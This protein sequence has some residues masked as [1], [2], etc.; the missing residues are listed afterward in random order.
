MEPVFRMELQ[1]LTP[2]L[3]DKL[4]IGHFCQKDLQL[5]SHN[6]FELAYVERGTATHQL[7][8]RRSVLK[9]G[10]YFVVDY[11]SAHSYADC[12]DFELI[13]CLFAPEALDETL[14]DCR[15]FDR[16]MRE[17][18]FHYQKIAVGQT[19]ANRVFSDADGQILQLLRGMLAE[20]TTRETGYAEIFRC[21]L[22]EILILTMR[23][24]VRQPGI[25][26]VGPAVEKLLEYLAQ[27]YAQPNLLSSFCRDCHYNIAYISR[28]FRQ[29][30]GTGYRQYLQRLRIEKSCRLL[31]SG[32]TKISEIAGQVGYT[33]VKTFHAVFR[34]LLG[35]T[36][37]AYRR[38]Y[39]ACF[40][41]GTVATDANRG[42]K[43]EEM[44]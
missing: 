6:F 24:L 10:D 40:I 16:L 12:H 22:I 18:L 39:T 32:D 34:R 13:N 25:E 43:S 37:R 27:H 30:T 9:A 41:R 21:R 38:Q 36:P 11:G 7:E 44:T 31:M 14:R 35:M 8:G 17:C 19:T 28:K 2:K 1:Q 33:D 15:S 20:Y 29:E 26:G 42:K 4:F 5:H 23:H 3:A